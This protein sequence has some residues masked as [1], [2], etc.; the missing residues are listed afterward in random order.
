MQEIY[1][2]NENGEFE[3]Y[4]TLK[5]NEEFVKRTI[6]SLKQ[7]AIKNQTDQLCQLEKSLGGYV[8]VFYVKNSVLY[9][10]LN[11]EPSNISR[12]LYLCTFIGY[13]T[14]EHKNV[15]VKRVKN[16]KTA[17]MTKKEIM[18]KMKL[19][20]SGFNKFYKEIK[21]KELI[22][23]TN[24]GIFISDK[25]VTK[26]N[27]GNQDSNFI[28]LFIDTTRY[29]Y[30]NCTIKQ[31]KTLSYVLQLIPFLDLQTNIILINGKKAEMKDIMTLLGLST[32]NRSDVSRFKDRLL[33]FHVKIDD[34]K[35]HLFA[36]ITIDYIDENDKFQKNTYVAIN[37]RVVWGGSSIECNNDIFNKLLLEE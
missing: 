31:H 12:F 1:I 20:K 21:D 15:I 6:P 23:E 37:P 18:E 17:P 2:K 25:Y 9:N 4:D 11:I 34:K 22:Y 5:S 7:Q 27:I 36:T 24:E 35:Y 19:S 3:L 14:T 10:E 8:N 32:K 30:E 13:N 28:R 29:L 33:K 26:G 16:N